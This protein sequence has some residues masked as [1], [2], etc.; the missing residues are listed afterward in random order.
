M[1]TKHS[2]EEEDMKKIS[3]ST[4]IKKYIK[5]KEKE[6]DR[7]CR[8]IIKQRNNNNELFMYGSFRKSGNSDNLIV[9]IAYFKDGFGWLTIK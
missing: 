5:R 3:L 6:L 1:N 2:Y 8:K 7:T 9:T 4:Y